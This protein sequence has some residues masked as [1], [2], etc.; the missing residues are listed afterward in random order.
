VHGHA[1]FHFRTMEFDAGNQIERDESANSASGILGFVQRGRVPTG[2]FDPKMIQRIAAADVYRLWEQGP[3]GVISF[4]FGGTAGNRVLFSA[5]KAQ[6]L[7][8]TDGER[9]GLRTWDLGY[10]TNRNSDAGNDEYQWVW[11]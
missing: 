6:L 1:G 5:P 4:Q 7:T 9:I 8:P 10:R 11:S 3:E 2:R